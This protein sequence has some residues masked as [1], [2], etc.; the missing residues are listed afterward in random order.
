MGRVHDDDLGIFP[1]H[2][3]CGGERY[4][5]RD[6]GPPWTITREMVCTAMTLAAPNEATYMGFGGICSFLGNIFGHTPAY[7][8][9]AKP[10]TITRCRDQRDLIERR[11]VTEVLS[12]RAL[13]NRDTV[14]SVWERV[15]QRQRTRSPWTWGDAYMLA[16]HRNKAVTGQ[17]Q[18]DVDRLSVLYDRAVDDPYLI[19]MLGCDHPPIPTRRIVLWGIVELRN[20][21]TRFV[22]IPTDQTDALRDA[23]DEF[24]RTLREAFQC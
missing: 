22:D 20:A 9:T 18:L 11:T 23:W 7:A 13:S 12:D 8:P 5:W 4:N 1:P 24:H 2:D 19:S 3:P 14:L 17:P 15:T 10:D 21:I 16:K 6:D